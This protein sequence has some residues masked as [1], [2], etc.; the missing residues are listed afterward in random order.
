VTAGAILSPATLDLQTRARISLGM[1]QSR[2][3]GRSHRFGHGLLARLL[4][5]GLVLAL[6]LTLGVGVPSAE[7]AVHEPCAAMNHAPIAHA[8]TEKGGEAP[9]PSDAAH[10]DLCCLFHCVPVAP[11]PL[12]GA[13]R[14]ATGSVALPLNLSVLAQGVTPPVGTPPPRAR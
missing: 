14:R 2:I 6:G 8:K 9:S 5:L 4:R 1:M 3:R 7:A 11:L 12:A 10:G 13:P